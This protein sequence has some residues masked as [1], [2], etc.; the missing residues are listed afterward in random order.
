MDPTDPDPKHCLQ[1]T[2][3]S[4]KQEKH[5]LEQE[6]EGRKPGKNSKIEKTRG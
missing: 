4:A 5:F 2:K 6:N 1:V 3:K